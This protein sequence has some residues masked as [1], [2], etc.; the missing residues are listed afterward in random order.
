M[1]QI[2]TAWYP[3]LGGYF[4]PNY[5]ALRV[6]ECLGRVVNGVEESNFSARLD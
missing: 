3:G 5:L 1:A 6:L 4:R 2:G